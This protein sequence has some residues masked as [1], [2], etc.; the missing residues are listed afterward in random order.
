MAAQFRFTNTQGRKILDLYTR[1]M[2]LARLAAK[3]DASEPTIRATIVRQ[4]GTIRGRGRLSSN[5]IT[6]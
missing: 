3:F 2:S 4:G 5:L 1:G 6:V